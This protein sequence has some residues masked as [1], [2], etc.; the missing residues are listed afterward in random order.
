MIVDGDAPLPFGHYKPSTQGVDPRDF[1]LEHPYLPLR[2]LS[3]RAFELH[4]PISASRDL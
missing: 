3:P 2:L 4:D 1:I